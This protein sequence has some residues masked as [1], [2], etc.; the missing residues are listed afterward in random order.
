MELSAADA[1]A[2]G[3]DTPIRKSGDLD[4]TP[5]I[6]IEGPRSRV[7]LER[8]VIRALRHV[9][10]SPSDADALGLKDEDYVAAATERHTRRILFRDVLV[11]VS[12]DLIALRGH[13]YR[14]PLNTAVP[15]VAQRLIR[16]MQRIPRR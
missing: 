15:Q 11:R 13:E 9:H 2:L 10:M 12:A 3:I 14:R 4:G 6:L 1:L 5:G 8:G 7:L 16:C